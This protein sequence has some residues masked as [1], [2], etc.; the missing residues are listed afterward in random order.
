MRDQV[1]IL[2]E[3]RQLDDRLHALHRQV[4][5][6]QA[7]SQ[8]RRLE[9]D[10]VRETLAQE[11]ARLDAAGR[12]K[13]EAEQEV[14]QSRAQKVKYEGQLQ[15]VKTNVEYQALL[16]E[17][18]TME[19]KARDWEDVILETMELEEATQRTA[20][21]LKADLAGKDRVAGEEGAR[22]E[23]ES[24]EARAQERELETRRLELIAGLDAAARHKYERLRA[25]KGETAIAAVA[26]GSCGG[27][28]YN[29]PPQTVNEVRRAERLILCEGCGRILVWADGPTRAGT[30]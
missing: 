24:T 17:I 6:R 4:E 2:L 15:G 26:H 22:V 13:R 29:L 30:P 27:C 3:L 5:A 23:R 10:L 1:A 11:T 9:A 16:K 19:A 12:R 8:R 7:D 20:E 25:V 28:H 21:R 18:A 14:K